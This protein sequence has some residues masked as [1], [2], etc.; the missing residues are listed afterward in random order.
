[1]KALVAVG[2]FL[3]RGNVVPPGFMQK[4]TGVLSLRDVSQAEGKIQ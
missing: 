2:S 1:M 3:R 4:E